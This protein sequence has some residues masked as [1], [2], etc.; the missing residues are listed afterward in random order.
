MSK[1]ILIADDEQHIREI[2]HQY[3]TNAGYQVFTFVSGEELYQ[4]FIKQGGDMII[5]DIMMPGRDGY[6]ICR[7]IRKT[8][9][10]PIIFVSA[11]DEE[12]D[13]ILGLELGSDDYLSKPFSPRELVVRVKN[14]F[15]R[16]EKSTP[17]KEIILSISD[18]TINPN[19]RSI[20][21]ENNEI[22]MTRKEFDLLYHLSSHTG[23]A[24]SRDQ[25]IEEIWGY[26][27]IGES[28]I[29]DD[30]IKRVR[31]KLKA[32]DSTLEITTLWGFGYKIEGE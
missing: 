5:L 26:E 30:V 24:F 14:I 12:L 23:Q 3:L 15:R 20:I 10:I 22:P 31:K 7:A 8:S 28:R 1:T 16:M 25:L 21:R 9:E 6:E 17:S 11:R 32:A 29:I 19:R 18:L 13:R 4:H 2:I 27:Y